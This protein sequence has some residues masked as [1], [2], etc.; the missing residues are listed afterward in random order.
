[1]N[2]RRFTRVLAILTASMMILSS[3]CTKPAPA[4]TT[5]IEAASITSLAETAKVPTSA[6]T[7]AAALTPTS[8]PVPTETIPLPTETTMPDLGPLN[9]SNVDGVNDPIDVIAQ[10]DPD[11]EN[12]LLLGIDGGD[13]ANIGHRSDCMCVLSINTRDNT[14][15]LSS[16]M[17][18]IKVY[19]PASGKWGKLNAAYQYGGPGQAVN[20][21]N[22]NFGLD[23]QKYF[24]LDF[25]SFRA[26]VDAIGGVD[27]E[28]TAKEAQ[29]IYAV[30]E[31]TAGVVHMDGFVSLVFCRVRK[32]DSDF[33]RVA[34]QRRFLIA[35]FNKLR[36]QDL[37]TQY[38]ECHNLLTIIRTN[39]GVDELTGQIYNFVLNADQNVTE[40]T[41][42]AAGMYTSSSQG[43]YYIKLDWE[44]Q[45]PALQAFIYGA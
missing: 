3:S 11:I 36:T 39:I 45:I 20:V 19:F 6:R 22:Y 21:I 18:D 29:T 17:R 8:T 4:E 2:T 35:V 26:A 14:V 15:K 24:V 30:P 33:S 7:A 41:V 16:L 5:P 40:Y 1:M 42:P 34:R 23:I 13:G 32:L 31:A 9:I 37:V 27:V 38:T 44:K 12:I 28:M 10:K 25:E 43:T